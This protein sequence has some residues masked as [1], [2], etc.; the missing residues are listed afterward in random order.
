MTNYHDYIEKKKFDVRETT[1]D[2]S[3]RIITYYILPILKDVYI[4]KLTVTVLK[5]W[6]LF[7]S[8]Q[9]YISKI[10]KGRY[11]NTT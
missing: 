5:K 3:K 1:L 4:D 10:E 6:K 7:K 2:K 9:K 8:N 11:R